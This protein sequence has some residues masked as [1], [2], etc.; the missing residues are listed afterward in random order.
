M[1][2]TIEELAIIMDKKEGF[3][4][5]QKLDATLR[6]LDHTKMIMYSISDV[7]DFV[8]FK[9]VTDNQSR[10]LHD[11][12][13]KLRKDGYADIQEPISASANDTRTY[14][15]TF[16][17]RVFIQSGGYAQK[18]IND[19]IELTY[20]KWINFSLIFGG[21]AAGVYYTYLLLKVM[22]DFLF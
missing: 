21:L 18:A 9:T 22:T 4:P 1:K 14:N 19:N 16:E 3:T 17:G 15:I 12:I 10:E 13:E 20:K 2:R 8:E 6:C 11:I 7:I 5:I